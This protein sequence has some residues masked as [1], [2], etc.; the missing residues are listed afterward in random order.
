LQF[1]Y[2][3]FHVLFWWTWQIRGDTETGKGSDTEKGS[4]FVS[5]DR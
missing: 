2:K 5:E 1:D 4:R 3:L